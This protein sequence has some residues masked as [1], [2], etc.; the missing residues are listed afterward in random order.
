[1][2]V[3]L[4]APTVGH[5]PIDSLARSRDFGSPQC[6]LRLYV[7]GAQESIID[8]ASFQSMMQF[9]GDFLSS[10]HNPSTISEVVDWVCDQLGCPPTVLVGNMQQDLGC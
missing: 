9:F 10:V 1:M 3:G 5:H 8:W 4:W 2:H 6:R 7:M